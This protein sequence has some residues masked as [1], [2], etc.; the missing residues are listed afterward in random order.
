MKSQLVISAVVLAT[1][2]LA[3]C[4]NNAPQNTSQQG[5][6]STPYPNNQNNQNYQNNASNYGYIESIQ[7]VR[8]NNNTS[9]GGAIVGGLVGGLLGN[10]VGNGNGR[11][12]ATVAG[13]IGGALVGNNVEQ[14]KNAQASDKYQIQIRL[15][16]G[17][18]TS[19][20]QDN[21]YDF[22]VGNRVRLID[23]RVDHY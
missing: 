20:M 23:G 21:I 16:N 1:A 14:N 15:D 7:V 17:S 11:T 12:A 18:T 2:A 8:P 5:S 13:A 10:Q 22:R 4:A 3:G 19:V 9:G 6:Y